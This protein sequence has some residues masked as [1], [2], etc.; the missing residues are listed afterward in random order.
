MKLNVYLGFCF[1]FALVCALPAHANLIIVPTFD[2][3]ITSDPNA[4][5]IESAVQSVISTFETD[6]ANNITVD[7]YF[8]E[9]PGLG[10]SDSQTSNISYTTFYNDLVANNANPAAIAG[11][12]SS[13]GNANTNGGLNPVT[14]NSQITLDSANLRA[15]G[16]N[17]APDCY[18]T[19]GIAMYGLPEICTGPNGGAAYDGVIALDVTATF[20]P[21]PDNGS[22]YS[23][24]SVAEHEIDEVLGTGSA[25][26]NCEPSVP[27]ATAA[28]QSGFINADNDAEGAPSPEDLYRYDNGLTLTNLQVNCS[29][30]IPEYF[31]YGPSTGEIEEFNSI[32]NNADF[33]D[34]GPSGL[35]QS[36]FGEPGVNPTLAAPEFDALSAIGYNLTSATTPEPALFVP[37]AC[38]MGLLVLR[39]RRGP[40]PVPAVVNESCGSCDSC[41][42]SISIGRDYKEW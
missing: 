5:V 14:N 33:G 26:Q 27:G 30:P 28:C 40:E 36:A 6:I 24:V 3:S 21:Q 19:S 11:L 10:T 4:A 41:S 17:Q 7:I 16:F 20:P 13:G 2:P 35:V 29:S 22:F 37:L 34:W 39:L 42:P 1:T 23:L 38:A 12:N 31:S 9:G 15:L 8:E 25:L 32:C 18:L